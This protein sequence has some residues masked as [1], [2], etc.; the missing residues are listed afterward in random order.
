MLMK[1]KPVVPSIGDLRMVVRDPP[2]DSLHGHLNRGDQEKIK[3]T[4]RK[5]RVLPNQSQLSLNAHLLANPGVVKI[6][7]DSRINDHASRGHYGNRMISLNHIRFE[8]ALEE[9]EEY[10]R[11]SNPLSFLSS[12][13]PLEQILKKCGCLW[14]AIRDI[15][16]PDRKG[17][18]SRP[19]DGKLMAEGIDGPQGCRTLARA[20]DANDGNTKRF[21]Y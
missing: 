20:I 13:Y 10:S 17:G 11:H 6:T 15:F 12:I 8:P 9:N 1:M 4:K 18:P 16:F 14:K 5:S 7:I 19:A 21:H 2:V 3:I